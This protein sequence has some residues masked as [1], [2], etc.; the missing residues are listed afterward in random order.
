MEINRRIV[1]AERPRYIIPTVNCFRMEQGAVPV[2]QEGQVLLRTQ[3]LS[4][5]P[6]LLSKVKRASPQADPV[7]L[8]D[9]MVG[10]TVGR[11]VTSKHP[12]YKAGDLVSG[13]WGWQDYAISDGTR[14]RKLPLDLKRPSHM[15]GALGYSGFGAYVALLE[16]GAAK[17]G[18]TAVI[19]TATGGLGQIAGQLAKLKGI[20]AVGIA[21]GPEK[22]RIATE[23]F[24]YDAC[25]DHHSRHFAEALKAACPK[26]VD[27]YVETIGGKVFDGVLPLFNL[28]ARMVICGLMAMYAAGG[29]PPGPDRTME[30]MNEVLLKRLQIK[31]MVTQDFMGRLYHDFK[32]QMISW[33]NSG[34]I[35]PMEY[36][37]EGLEQAPE[38]LQGM[39]EG[40]NLGK[41]LVHVAD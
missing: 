18:E 23:R 37:V 27:V 26:G 3:W 39:F 13:F 12:A 32:L 36:I 14:M 28:N 7:A 5:D 16:L 15:L 35:K 8:G 31:G 4:M 22:C 40:R 34:Q 29:L 24:G 11:V 1:L 20:R 25:I 6:Y 21:G 33:I 41:P 9:V 19:G 10:P 30:V 2:P 38:A 17:P